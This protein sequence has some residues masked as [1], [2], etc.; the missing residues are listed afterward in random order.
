MA[1]SGLFKEKVPLE[2]TSD[3]ENEVSPKY[4]LVLFPQT[5]C[6]L[7]WKVLQRNNNLSICAIR[8]HFSSN[9][10]LLSLCFWR[11]R[12]PRALAQPQRQMW[13]QKH[14]RKA[15]QNTRQ[16]WNAHMGT[17]GCTDGPGTAKPSPGSST[18]WARALLRKRPNS[19]D[20]L[21]QTADFLGL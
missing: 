3:L 1:V 6:L 15:R 12:G 10:M 16:E 4:T 17:R 2:T 14:K 11:G 8:Y 7:V 20:A 5:P 19:V 9:L 13:S 18:A 21:P